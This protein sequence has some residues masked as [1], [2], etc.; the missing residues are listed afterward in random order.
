MKIIFAIPRLTY[1]GAP[2][3]MAWVANRMAKRGHE[4]KFVTY[5]SGERGRELEDNIDFR[6]IN[7][8]QS[9]S[10]FIRNTVGMLKTLSALDKYVKSEKPDVF[11]SFLDSVGYMYLPLA[12]KRCKTVVSERVDPYVYKG[13][14]SKIRFY[15]MSILLVCTI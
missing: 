12:R 2:K 1:S 6:Y 9:K 8:V 3:M 11:V 15:L 13:I 5:F 14:I 10:R 4:V 7:V